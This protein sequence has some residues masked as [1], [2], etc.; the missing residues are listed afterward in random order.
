MIYAPYYPHEFPRVKLFFQV[1]VVYIKNCCSIIVFPTSQYSAAYNNNANNNRQWQETCNKDGESSGKIKV[2]YVSNDYSGQRPKSQTEEKF[3]RHKRS[4]TWKGRLGA[5]TSVVIMK[6][7]FQN[8]TLQTSH[9]SCWCKSRPLNL[10]YLLC[11]FTVLG[12]LIFYNFNKTEWKFLI[13]EK[14]NC[15][16]WFCHSG[17]DWHVSI[18]PYWF[19]RNIC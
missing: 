5:F 16:V 1:L 12:P 4:T 2:L 3:S 6:Y 8:Q 19:W 13:S 11:W 7:F 17:C 9:E 14:E 15:L 18:F 10:I